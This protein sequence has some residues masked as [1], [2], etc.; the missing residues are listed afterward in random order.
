MEIK[1]LVQFIRELYPDKQTI[2]LHE[3]SFFGNEKKYIN[4]TID[5][6]FVSSVGQFVTD[7]EVELAKA[8]GSKYAVAI[9][10]GTAALH[11]A[12]LL[13]GVK[14]DDIVLTQP[15][16]FIATCNAISYI[17]AE[18]LFVDIDKDTLGLSPVALEEYLHTNTFTN[19]LGCFDKK[20][21][22]RV[23]ACVPMHTFGHPVRIDLL[24]DVCAK[25]NIALIED[26]AESIGSYYT[27]IHTGNFG[28]VSAMSFNG[29]K[30]ITCGG[31][32]A[33]LTNDAALA[34]KAK[35]LTTQAKVPHRWEFNHDS[36][37]F[38]YRMPNI[39]AALGCAQLEKLD[40]ILENKRETAFLYKNFFKDSG[41]D[42]VDEPSD[43]RSNFW[44]NAVLAKNKQERDMLLEET[45]NNKIFTR[46]CWTLMHKLPMFEQMRRENLQNAEW[47]AD[48]LVNLP[49]SYRLHAR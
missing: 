26:A 46:P 8:T 43:G 13:G 16:S 39:N 20:S 40:E 7:F 21:N 17:G 37:A 15:L 3:A 5:T 49:S 1:K 29:N 35:H 33:I 19:E 23:A 38:N 41:Y 47:V 10:N 9:V 45:N 14:R 11:I 24:K 4:E 48:R 32:G 30:T 6:T 22:K 42:F 12:L 27:N 44:L 18:P 28:L 25:F 36:I 34:K 2:A 31:G